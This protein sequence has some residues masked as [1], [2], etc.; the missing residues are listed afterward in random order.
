MVQKLAGAKAGADL[1]AASNQYKFV[2]LN[3]DR[4]VILCAALTDVPIG[5][6]QEPCKNGDAAD[7]LVVG[8][9]QVQ[10]NGSLSAGQLIGTDASGLANHVVPGTDITKYI[11]GQVTRVAGATTSGNFATA[12][13]NC[14]SPSRAA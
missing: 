12:V 6:L 5:V 8:E 2:K 14:A 10:V 7:V 1:S 9:T 4:Q 3:A 13:I 11:V